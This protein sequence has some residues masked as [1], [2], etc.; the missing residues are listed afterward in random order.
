MCPQGSFDVHCFHMSTAAIGLQYPVSD[1]IK[2]SFVIFDIRALWRS[3][4]CQSAR[5]SKLTNDSLTQSDIG[6][7]IVVPT[8]HMATVDF[9]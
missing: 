2:Q 6:Y 1:R 3:S 4:L 9:N 8:T 7:F 5:M